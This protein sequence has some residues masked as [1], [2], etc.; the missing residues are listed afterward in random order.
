MHEE[1]NDTLSIVFCALY[2]DWLKNKELIHRSFE[3]FV[4]IWEERCFFI[5]IIQDAKQR[6][7]ELAFKNMHIFYMQERGIS[8]ARNRGVEEACTLNS[9]WII[10]HDA[11]ICWTEEAVGFLFKNRFSK[12]SPK[13]KL[14]FQL[15]EEKPS[16]DVQGEIRKINPVYDTYV[17]S[18]L[19]EVQSIA[20]IRFNIFHGPG[21]NT[22]YKSGEDVLFF[23]DYFSMMKNFCVYESKTAY[24]YHPPREKDFSKHKIYAKGQGRVFKILLKE[25]FSIRLLMDCILFFG[26]ALVRCIFFR[27]NSFYILKERCV[28]FFCED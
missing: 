7:I 23:F 11:S 3:H 22:I 14:K 16:T 6:K 17:G 15:I 9:R 21:Q 28:G 20:K 4:K 10:F 25:Y 2:D 24:I 27:K 5:L 12:I 13:V 19:F 1:Y 18:V 26:N 8:L